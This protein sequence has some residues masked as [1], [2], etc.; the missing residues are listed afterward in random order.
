MHGVKQGL[1]VWNGLPVFQN[2]GIFWRGTRFGP[3][4]TLPRRIVSGHQ[5]YLSIEEIR[6]RLLS[7]GIVSLEVIASPGLEVEIFLMLAISRPP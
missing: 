7:G 2:G 6:A 5:V 1:H 3:T 4:N